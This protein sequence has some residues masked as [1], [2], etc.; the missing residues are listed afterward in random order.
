[1]A[2]KKFFVSAWTLFIFSGAV[3]AGHPLVTD[4]AGVV[5]REAYELEVGYESSRDASDLID[6][7]AGI[8]FKHGITE[9]MDIGFS[10]PYHVDPAETENL[11]PVSVGA[12]FSLIKDTL[13]LSLANE[14]GAKDY[15]INAI[16]SREIAAVKCSLNAGY[17]STGDAAVK[18]IGSYGVS[19]ELPVGKFD[20]LCELQAQEGGSG[21][22]LAGLRYHLLENIFVAAGFSKDF[23]TTANKLTLGSHLEF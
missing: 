13:A 21:N 17:L 7:N 16:Y 9:K 1:M 10:M 22:G 12:K 4:D 15:Y 18:G 23:Q 20:I 3:F 5:P 19:A 8:S 14:L 2:L 6:N 11:G